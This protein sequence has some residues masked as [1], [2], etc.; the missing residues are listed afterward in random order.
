MNITHRHLLNVLYNNRAMYDRNVKSLCVFVVE[1]VRYENGK[2]EKRIKKILDPTIQYHVT[3]EDHLL[4]HPVTYIDESHCDSYE[5]RVEDVD[6]HSASL[7]GQEE[8]FR[9]MAGPGARKR[10]RQIHMHRDLHGSDVRVED[11][12]IDRYLTRFEDQ[13]DPSPDLELAFSDIE[14]DQHGYEHFPSEEEAPCPINIISY[15]HRP[16]R[17]LHQYHNAGIG[18]KSQQDFLYPQDRDSEIKRVTWMLGK[19]NEG[20]ERDLRCINIILYR[21]SC[22]EDLLRQY[23]AKVQEDSPDFNLFWNMKFD[24]LTILNRMDRL[25]MRP[26]D[27]FCEKGHSPYDILEYMKDDWTQDYIFKKDVMRVS[28]RTL[29]VDQMLLYAALR[30][31]M[32]KKPSYALDAILG[33]EINEGKVKYEGSIRDF[34][35]RDYPL[36]SVYAAIDVIASSTLEDRLGDVEFNHHLSYLTR[37]GFHDT[38][39]KTRCLRNLAAHYYRKKGFVLSNNRNAIHRSAR[40]VYKGGFVSS[41]ERMDAAGMMVGGERSRRLFE[42]VVDFDATSLYPSIFR[43]F[44]IDPAGQY[45]QMVIKEDGGKEMTA[46]FIMEALAGGKVEAGRRLLGLPGVDEA[47][48]ALSLGGD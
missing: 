19:V 11:H 34:P 3:K 13:Y 5:S 38:M 23:L 47:L 35:R 15:F 7:T 36:F 46:E 31:H 10:R 12:Y 45:G 42:S 21:C 32:A 39:M 27:H 25:G 37:T 16:T 43:A 4:D 22:E 26:T 9:D 8:A 20:H 30:R 24:A 14:V 1:K 48:Q 33:Y 40:P 28:S 29:W 17:T 18:N 6:A 44:N 41:P 2:K